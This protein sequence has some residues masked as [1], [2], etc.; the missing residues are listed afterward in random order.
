MYDK[1]TLEKKRRQVREL[2]KKKNFNKKEIAQRFL[3]R[4]G[5]NRQIRELLTD[6]FF[7]AKL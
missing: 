3:S 1:E 4:N 6:E 7:L 2:Y 5:I